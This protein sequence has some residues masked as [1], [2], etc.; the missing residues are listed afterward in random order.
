[1]LLANFG[2]FLEDIPYE[3]DI[4]G[5]GRLRNIIPLTESGQ[6]YL[7]MDNQQ[8]TPTSIGIYSPSGELYISSRRGFC[9]LHG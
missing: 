1:M 3:T 9:L 5:K 2:T 8:E 6:F 7:I 4:V